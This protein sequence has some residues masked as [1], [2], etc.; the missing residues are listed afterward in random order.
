MNIFLSLLI[1]NPLEA[2]VL[3]LAAI[4][5]KSKVFRKENI[6]HFYILGTI[7]FILQYLTWEIKPSLVGLFITHFY[8][9]FIS[10]FILKFYIITFLKI[11]LKFITALFSMLYTIVTIMIC[12]IIINLFIS[13]G[14]DADNIF[15]EIATNVLIKLFQ[16][17]LLY[18]FYG[19]SLWSRKLKKV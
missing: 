10:A 11:N 12:V 5:D 8:S 9:I 14:T 13:F 4:G 1:F 7:N 17:L 19:R 3:F 18:L 2:V 15:E 6:K 16:F